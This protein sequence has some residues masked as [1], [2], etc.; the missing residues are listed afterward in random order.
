MVRRRLLVLSLVVN[1]VVSIALPVLT[2]LPDLTLGRDRPLLARYLGRADLS[3]QILAAAEVAGVPVVA[4]RRDILA[5]LFYTGQNAAVP[6]FALP[7]PGRPMNHYEQVYPLP[8]DLAGRVLF[9]ADAP[10]TCSGRPVPPHVAFD[11]S[12]GA[13]SRDRF[14]GYLVPAACL[15]ARR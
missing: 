2:L 15:H 12:V 13:Y 6:V 9:V 1:G 4:D 3:R 7:P 10:P 11:T 5:D 14:A 8:A